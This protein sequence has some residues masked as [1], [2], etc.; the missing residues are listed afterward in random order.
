MIETRKFGVTK[1]GAEVLCFTLKN[2]KI[3]VEILNY[4]GVIRA[5]YT[6]GKQGL[7]DV[8]LGYDTLAEYEENDGY[9]GA[10][11]GRV[12][13]RIRD[14]KMT[15]D[16]KEYQLAQND[17]TRTLHGGKEGFDRKI[18]SYA[19]EDDTLILRYFSPHM[20]E[21]FPGNLM[22][23]ARYSLNDNAL[24]LEYTACADAKTPINLTN[25]SYFNLGGEGSG[26][27]LNHRLRLLSDRYTAIDGD[28]LPVSL[29]PVEGT[30]FD[31]RQGKRIGEEIDTDF[32]QL[33]LGHGYD[34]NYCLDSQD[35]VSLFASVYCPETGILLDAYTDL[36]GVQF[37]SGNFLDQNG[38]RSHYGKRSG[39]CLE[40]QF[41]PDSVNHPEFPSPFFNDG[42]VY[43]STTI[44]R[45]S[46]SSGFAEDSR[47]EIKD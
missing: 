30:P 5:L 43:E 12:A 15:V 14:G 37:Y 2:E 46:V 27:V 32:P 18:W 42:E 29:E 24:V 33:R 4:G 28:M 20:E 25:H 22:A 45:F 34:H 35:K 11:I 13:N 41:Y 38:K 26:T 31:F 7:C 39:F 19:L 21:N 44:Y 23:E 9:L 8:V 40:T 47:K 1:N 10:V 36:P 6:P 16:G 3:A 17:R